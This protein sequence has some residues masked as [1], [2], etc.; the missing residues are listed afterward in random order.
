MT[1]RDV[2]DYIEEWYHDRR[3]TEQPGVE[4]SPEHVATQ[5]RRLTALYVETFDPES[6]DADI[7][8]LWKATEAAVKRWLNETWS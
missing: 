5:V 3:N 1:D 7:H 4:V 8:D 6:M 2:K